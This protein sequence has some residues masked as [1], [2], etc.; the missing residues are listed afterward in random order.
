MHA[1]HG[2]VAQL[3]AGGRLARRTHLGHLAPVP[4]H[5]CAGDPRQWCGCFQGDETA[6]ACGR[7]AAERARVH[8]AA[9]SSSCSAAAP[10]TRGVL[11]QQHLSHLNEPA[12]RA[13]VEHAPRLRAMPGTVS[14]R[15]A[16]ACA[17]VG[18]PHSAAA[19]SLGGPLTSQ[20][21]SSSASWAGAGDRGPL[22]SD[23]PAAVEAAARR[24]APPAAARQEGAPNSSIAVRR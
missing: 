21:L 16:C 20:N 4:Q 9:A 3:A 15:A 5:P 19:G 6:R 14:A 23:W 10:L 24:G 2:W 1:P 8:W 22:E 7:A 12:P 18:P 11:L 17:C 13:C